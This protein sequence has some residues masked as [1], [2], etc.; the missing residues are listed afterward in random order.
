M[1]YQIKIKKHITNFLYFSTLLKF[2]CL[3]QMISPIINQCKKENLIP[4]NDDSCILEYCAEQN[5]THGICNIIMIG[6][7]DFSYVNLAN[8][9][10]GDLVVE[11]TSLPGSS[12]RMFYGI[13]KDGREFFNANDPNKKTY[14]YSIEAKDQI[15][16]NNNQ[17][18]EAEIFMATINEGENKGKQ[19]L[20]SIGINNSYTELYDFDHDIIYQNQTSTF[21][22]RQMNNIR[23]TV[24]NYQLNNINYV[25]FGYINSYEH[26]FYINKLKFNEIDIG[27]SNPNLNYFNNSNTVGKTL[28]CFMTDLKYIMCFYANFTNYNYT[29][30]YYYNYSYNNNY[31]YN[32]NYNIG[33]IKVI[34]NI[35]DNKNFSEIK[36]TYI[37][38]MY[39][40]DSIFFKAIHYKEEVGIFIYYYYY[41]SRNYLYPYQ[42]TI[43]YN[44]VILFK[45]YDNDL[46]DYSSSFIRTVLDKRVFNFDCSLNDLI[47][48]STQKICFLSTSNG[49][50][51]LYIVLI[52]IFGTEKLIIR[53]YDIETFNLYSYK[54]FKN[55]RAHLY[56]DFIAFAFSFCR[57]EICVDENSEHY[58]GFMI[59]NY[60]NGTDINL[61]VTD[62]L[63]RNNDI[64]INNITINLVNNTFIENNIF[65]YVYSEVK[66]LDTLNCDGIN[67]F[68]STKENTKITFDYPLDKNENIKIEFEKYNTIQCVI[69]YAYFATERSYEEDEN[70]KYYKIKVGNDTKESYDS[71]KGK[72]KGKSIYYKIILEKELESNC[73]KDNC[74]LCLKDQLSYCITCK[75]N[76]T[77]FETGDKIDNKTCYEIEEKKTETTF[78]E[79]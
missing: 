42:T 49:K 75:E 40:V 3:F 30:N 58:S 57:Q 46:V 65:G 6:D 10:N 41:Y 78:I 17:R 43:S 45:K 1:N 71:Q 15:R 29:Y 16:N 33:N 34:Q 54:F 12:K 9:S 38:D 11:T 27:T 53:Y 22:S 5:S 64:N 35:E 55:I 69:E 74:L 7:K 62:Y 79:P 19:Y 4:F 21:L 66:V 2:I 25:L 51:I 26:N 56:N 61:N 23:G 76:F 60:P 68:S 13:K 44:P 28:S 59:F 14:Y 70:E 47:K 31:N 77:L 52:N 20:V 48:I 73:K 63:L 18:L 72:Y 67:L 39:I 36:G 37:Q 24:I 8:Y 50:D 32:Y